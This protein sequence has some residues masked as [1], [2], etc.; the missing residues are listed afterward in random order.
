MHWDTLQQN[1][2]N[3][4]RLSW[5]LATGLDWRTAMFLPHLQ[6]FSWAIKKAEAGSAQCSNCR[7]LAAHLRPEN[8]RNPFCHLWTEN[9]SG[10]ESSL[11]SPNP[12]SSHVSCN[13]WY[14]KTNV[15]IL[16]WRTAGVCRVSLAFPF[17]SWVEMDA[18]LISAGGG[19]RWE[20]RPFQHILMFI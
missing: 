13:K 10:K 2:G 5:F 3:I 12:Y 8:S 15:Y 17:G 7:S 14:Q 19:E 9:A 16:L 4:W 6:G 18:R 1:K 20:E 11:K